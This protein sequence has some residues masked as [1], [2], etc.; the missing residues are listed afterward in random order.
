MVEPRT[1]RPGGE[2]DRRTLLR[3]KARR[4]GINGSRDRLAVRA[5]EGSTG[6]RCDLTRETLH[7]HRIASV[8]RDRELEQW[9][10]EVEDHTQIRP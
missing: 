2:R 3:R 9:I 5:A 8:R 7:R 1:R 10:V 6:E 4:G